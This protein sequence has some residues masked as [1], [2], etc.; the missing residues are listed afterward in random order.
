MVIW[1]ESARDDL[2][3]IHN[4]IALSSVFYAKKTVR[5]IV[6]STEKL[7]EMPQVGRIVP[8][9]QDPDIRE[10]FVYSYRIIYQ[11]MPEK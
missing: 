7:S 5:D 2:K 11:I 10:V 3:A 1:T 4:Y 6:H 9:T 8:E